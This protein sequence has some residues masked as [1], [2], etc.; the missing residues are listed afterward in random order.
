MLSKSKQIVTHH[1]SRLICFANKAAREGD[2]KD[3]LSIKNATANR[4]LNV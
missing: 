2:D 4:W 1:H 3:S